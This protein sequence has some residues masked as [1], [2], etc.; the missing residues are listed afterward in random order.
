MIRIAKK[1]NGASQ[2]K[3][4]QDSFAGNPK[5]YEEIASASP[6]NKN[7][8]SIAATIHYLNPILIF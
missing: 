3:S 4:H 2:R 8:K 6:R 5:K 7:Y 1:L